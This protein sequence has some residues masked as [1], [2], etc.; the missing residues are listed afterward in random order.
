MSAAI[1]KGMPNKLREALDRLASGNYTLVPLA[2][3]ILSREPYI[4]QP[5]W[6]APW[7]VRR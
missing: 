5:A 6:D 7:W 3:E 2:S 1:K 4:P